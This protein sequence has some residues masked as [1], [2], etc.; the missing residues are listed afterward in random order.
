VG[1]GFPYPIAINGQ[2][3]VD[4]DAGSPRW[5]ADVAWQPSGYQQSYSAG[6]SVQPL[7]E[8]DYWRT[9]FV[10]A[11]L[12]LIQLEPPWSRGYRSEIDDQ[13]AVGGEL[14]W[15]R[16]FLSSKQLEVWAA[17]GVL[18]IISDTNDGPL[19]YTLDVGAAWRIFAL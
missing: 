17:F 7:S 12:R 18:G 14:G 2:A 19:R 15:R 16:L 11:R 3:L 9:L 1:T 10:G 6:A 5:E 13:W 4:D 8:H